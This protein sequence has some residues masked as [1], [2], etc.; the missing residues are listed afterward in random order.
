MKH[1]I[2]RY[3]LTRF[4]TVVATAAMLLGSVFVSSAYAADMIKVGFIVY[5]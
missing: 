3:G 5:R 2:K 1:S 4:T